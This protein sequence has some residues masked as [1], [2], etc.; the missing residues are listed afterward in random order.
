[1]IF[2]WFIW[3]RRAMGGAAMVVTEMTCVSPDARITPAC[4]GMWNDEQQQAWKRIV[5]FVHAHTDAKI[6]L[7]L[8]HSGRKGSTRRRWEGID[9]PLDS[10]NWPLISASPLPYIEGVSQIPREATRDD[11]DRIQAEFVAATQTRRSGGIRLAGIPLR[12]RLSDVELYFASD[13]SPHRSVRRLA[14]KSLPLSAGSF[15]GDARGVA[16]GEADECAH[17]RAR[18]GSRRT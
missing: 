15:P 16:A 9:Q 5:D 3:A 4:P 11:M 18:L 14:R 10:G 13:Q 1:M 17:L 6:A 7:Q 2:I 8:G 12:A